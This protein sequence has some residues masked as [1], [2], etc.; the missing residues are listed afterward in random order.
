M[1]YPLCLGIEKFFYQAKL[2]D[3]L[4]AS[5]FD[6]QGVDQSIDELF[7]NPVFLDRMLYR[8]TSY[9]AN[10]ELIEVSTS[11]STILSF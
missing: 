11:C 10:K 6:R 4:T 8:T 7:H 5:L 9:L 2:L 1:M 3:L